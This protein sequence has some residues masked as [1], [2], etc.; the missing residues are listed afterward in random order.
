MAE[1][2][3]D[4]PYLSPTADLRLEQGRW[5]RAPFRL[6]ILHTALILVFMLALMERW[7]DF[8]PYPYNCVY[9][10]YFFISGPLVYGVAHCI[11]H[12]FDPWLWPGDL[13]SIRLAWNLIPGSICLVLGGVQWWLIEVVYLRLRRR[14]S[15]P[16]GTG[17]L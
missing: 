9:P 10:P 5:S 3:Q 17:R 11:Q 16:T 14:S 7:T 6:L 2:V 4:N 13:D 12:A 8:G 15:K 1:T